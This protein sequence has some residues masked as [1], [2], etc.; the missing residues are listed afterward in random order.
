[1]SDGPLLG[2]FLIVPYA[3]LA[4]VCYTGGW[5]AELLVRAAGKADNATAFG[6]KAFRVGVTFSILI[7]LSP[8]VICWLSFAVALFKG[9][10][11]GPLG[12]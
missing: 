4:N 5:V 8:A 6:L 12:A 11:H 7:T 2:L 3:V 1:M 10:K 9:Q